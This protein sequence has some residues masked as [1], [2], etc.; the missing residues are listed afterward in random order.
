MRNKR[1]VSFFTVLLIIFFTIGYFG[2]SNGKDVEISE[3]VKKY[4]VDNNIKKTKITKLSDY[5]N[6]NYS[7][8]NV[9]IEEISDDEINEL[10]DMELENNVEIRKIKRS[11][12]KKGDYIYIDYSMYFNEVQIGQGESET[13][14][15]GNNTFCEEIEKNLL[16]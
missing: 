8:P 9:G 1:Y 3:Q 15:V 12:V 6:I 11:K 4:L 2:Y 10:I 5:N 7:I 14:L 13:V 16:D